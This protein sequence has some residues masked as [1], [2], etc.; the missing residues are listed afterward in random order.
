[1]HSQQRWFY[2]GAG[3]EVSVDQAHRGYTAAV[4]GAGL[5]SVNPL[6]WK[7][8]PTAGRFTGQG[9]YGYLSFARFVDAATDVAN[10]AGQAMFHARASERAFV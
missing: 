8:A 1:M 9:C 3:G 6:F 2:L 7:P 5:A 4:H 10:G